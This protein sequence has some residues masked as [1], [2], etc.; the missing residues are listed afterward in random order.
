MSPEQRNP[1]ADTGPSPPSTPAAPPPG[2][3]RRLARTERSAGCREPRARE[4]LDRFFVEAGLT[5]DQRERQTFQSRRFDAILRTLGDIG[6]RPDWRVLDVGAGTGALA[7]AV[8]SCYGGNFQLADYLEPTDPLR[9][10]LGTQGIQQF[11]RCDLTAA[12]PFA[13]LGS[14]WD[15]V[16]FIEVLEHLLVNPVPLLRRLGGLLRPEGS[17]VLS[18]PNQA[19]LRNRTN[20]LRGRAVR[21][22]D[23][24][25]DHDAPTFG[26]VQEYTVE[27]LHTYLRRAG[28]E[29]VSTRVVQNLPSRTPS[30]TQ[31]MG[32]RWLN[33]GLARRW[34][35]GD[36]MIVVAKPGGGRP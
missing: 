34:A 11:A 1:R 31:R 14:S 28:L 17:L 32:T 13:D 2:P 29:P 12:E 18:T 9:Q 26:H 10:A 36:E 33:S 8:R 4:A 15:L 21:E 27:E 25:P 19:R 22:K 30:R 23:A 16:L 5:E 20:L 35:L 6:M 24:F 3:S 7:V